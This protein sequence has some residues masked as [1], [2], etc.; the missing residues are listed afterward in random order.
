VAMEAPL[1]FSANEVRN[2]KVDVLHAIRPIPQ[3]QVNHCAVRGQYG[4]GWIEGEHV[5][6]YRSE[7]NVASESST[8]T[9]AAVKLFVDNWRWQ[10]VPF[11]LRTAKRLPARVSEVAIQ[12]RAVPHQTF[13]PSAVLDWRANRLIIA[14]Q[15]EEGI[16]L[17]F[18]A[19][20]PGTEM[21]LTP[22]VMQFYYREAFKIQSPEAYE[23]LLLD[24][25]RGDATLF[26]RDDQ[27]E[28]AWAVI[29][30]IMEAWETIRPM[31]FPNYQAGTWGPE[32]ADILIAQDG[33]SWIMPTFLRCQADAATCQVVAEPEP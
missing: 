4:G 7:P 27:A 10:D 20:Y 31:E 25:M 21:L 5:L 30:P 29:T 32:T 9:F 11:Y 23:T 33:R 14:I 19:K 1:S 18:E 22:V 13:P 8:E 24:V 15:P 12:F 17:R 3:E 16:L 6:G 2:K 28:A 26:M